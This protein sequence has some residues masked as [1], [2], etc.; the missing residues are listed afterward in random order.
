MNFVNVAIVSA[1]AQKLKMT[2]ISKSMKKFIF[3]V[4]LWE[5]SV[6][7]QY[8]NRLQ[9]KAITSIENV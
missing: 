2:I 4:A 3:S 1:I 9:S 5:M 8:S 6:P 7:A